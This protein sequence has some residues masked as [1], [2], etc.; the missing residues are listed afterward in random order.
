[1]LLFCDV[2]GNGD[3]I[4]WLHGKNVIPERQYQYFFYLLEEIEVENY[5]VINDQL[6]L[7]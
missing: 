7:K 4:S 6:V 3:I 1:M 2:D 5:L